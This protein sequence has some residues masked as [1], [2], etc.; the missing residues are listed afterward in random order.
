M[1]SDKQTLHLNAKVWIEQG[2]DNLAGAVEIGLLLAIAETGSINQAA[3]SLGRSYKWA[4]DT[5]EAM[6]GMA[7]SPLVVRETGGKNGGGTRLTERGEQLVAGFQAIERAHAAYV[8]ALSDEAA[9]LDPDSLPLLSKLA[10]KTSARNQL[11][12]VV[13]EINE[14]ARNN[15]VVLR[16]HGDLLLR[17][18]ITHPSIENL[19]LYVG[20]EAVA[21]IKALWIDI[22]PASSSAPAGW[23]ALPGK[24]QSMENG[25]AAM[26]LPHYGRLFGM[27]SDEDAARL[28][29]GDDVLAVFD[30]KSVILGVPY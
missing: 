28:K 2:K 6:N 13:Q 7:D 22:V 19:A 18:Q 24:I 10:L 20:K 5:V 30:S 27:I 12:G 14:A 29:E 3:K 1:Q 16:L 9:S 21:L 17:V 26:S 25:E 15:E 4:W 11:F 23:N 8:G